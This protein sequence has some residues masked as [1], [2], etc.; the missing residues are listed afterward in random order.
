MLLAGT[1]TLLR[2]FWRRYCGRAVSGARTLALAA[3]RPT[4]WAAVRARDAP[5]RWPG[6]ER[7]SA[8]AVES[9]AA[10][11]S[12]RGLRELRRLD[13]AMRALRQRIRVADEVAERYRRDADSAGSGMFELLSGLVAA[14][15]GTRGQLAAEL[16][17]TVAQSLGAARRHAHR[18]TTPTVWAEVALIEE[19]EERFARRWPAPG[20]RRCAT[21]TWPRRSASLRDDFDIRYG[22]ERRRSNGRVRSTRCRWSTAVT[23]YRFFQEGLLNVAQA[24]RRRRGA[25]AH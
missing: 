21:A 12:S 22:L 11:R 24:R 10:C 1:A 18:P 3:G 25:R 16:H 20:R 7:C 23:I 5:A 14:E 2:D 4:P 6:R 8:A 17:D 9:V 19:A 15:E 13:E